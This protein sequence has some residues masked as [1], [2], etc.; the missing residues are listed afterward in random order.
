MK[1][2]MFVSV[3]CLFLLISCG[4]GKKTAKD[5]DPNKIKSLCEWLT[6]IEIVT[7]EYAAWL[8]KSAGEFKAKNGAEIPEADVKKFEEQKAFYE[9]L[10]K[11]IEKVP[12]DKKWS[13][14]ASAMG[15]CDNFLARTLAIAVTSE[16]ISSELLPNAEG[17]LNTVTT[18]A[19]K[20]LQALKDKDYETA[21]TYATK[22][23]AQNLDMMKSL[24]SDF[25][26]TE[27]KDVK[28]AIEADMATCTFCC[29]KDTSFKELKLKKEGTGW[30]AHQ[31]KETPP[32]EG[33]STASNN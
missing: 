10:L 25:G 26:L 30:L 11:D 3:G 1:K 14:D 32:I 4:G 24:S 28:C 23:T 20:Y 7:N 2:L 22:E 19:Q 15:K 6:A 12:S 31:P 16:K 18:I 9:K 8:E 17:Y 29:T 5:I 27:V 33:D 21:K 13:D